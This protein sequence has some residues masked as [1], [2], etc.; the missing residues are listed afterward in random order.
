MSSFIYLEVDFEEYLP[1][2][3]IWMQSSSKV[4]AFSG[5]KL[6]VFMALTNNW[7]LF[8]SYIFRT[9]GLSTK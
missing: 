9:L 8:S 7:W 6:K 1:Q 2:E 3:M 5:V 4:L